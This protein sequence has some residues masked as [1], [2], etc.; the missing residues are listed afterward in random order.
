MGV[1]MLAGCCT[2]APRVTLAPT[3]CA[4]PVRISDIV[5]QIDEVELALRCEEPEPDER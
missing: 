2:L 5:S 4:W 3:A 1:L